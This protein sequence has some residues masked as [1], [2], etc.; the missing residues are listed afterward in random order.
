MWVKK[1]KEKTTKKANLFLFSYA[2]SLLGSWIRFAITPMFVYSVTKS[3][4]YTG[5][6]VVVGNLSKFLVMPLIVP[7]L[8]NIK[9]KNMLILFSALQG[10]LVLFYLFSHNI[11]MICLVIMAIAVVADINNAG[12]TYIVKSI[13]KEKE[14]KTYN[15][16]IVTISNVFVFWGPSIG[17]F[18]AN[19]H[20]FELCFL[21]DSITFFVY[22]AIVAFLNLD[23]AV[24]ESNKNKPSK[25]FVVQ[26]RRLLEILS[27]KRDEF[28]PYILTTII[29]W[30]GYGGILVIYPVMCLEI[31]DN[32][33]AYGILWSVIGIGQL[34]GGYIIGKV[35]IKNDY[36]VFYLMVLF[37]GILHIFIFK[38]SNFG[39][40]LGLML[41]TTFFEGVSMVLENCII[42]KAVLKNEIFV[43]SST[44]NSVISLCTL[45]GSVLSMVILENSSFEVAGITMSII[46][47]F[48]FLVGILRR[49]RSDLSTIINRIE[50]VESL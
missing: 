32:V 27:V 19:R 10:I 41:I 26:Y 15:S 30:I 2:I 38:S 1:L 28:Y 5:I 44:L 13:T 16:R 35:T 3:I 29:I 20:G 48:G 23:E 43:I 42:Q 7:Y 25:T 12:R 34:I 4:S 50:K 21:I 37:S 22:A 39:I 33:N 24:V 6:S 40:T 49:N 14:L 45:V 17:G 31:S 36:S 11:I 9:K 46:V 47:I 8:N 18:I